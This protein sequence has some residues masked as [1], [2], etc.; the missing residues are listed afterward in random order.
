MM[1]DVLTREEIEELTGCKQSYR[2]VEWLKENKFVFMR[3]I[4][5][6]ARVDRAHYEQRVGCYG[7]WPHLAGTGRRVL[8]QLPEPDSLK[9]SRELLW[10]AHQDGP[11]PVE[12]RLPLVLTPEE[13]VELTGYKK[14]ADQILWLKANKFTF[15]LGRASTPRVDR[16][17]YL[18]RMGGKP[19]PAS[20]DEPNWAALA[21]TAKKK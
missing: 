7:P 9:A 10:K 16:T 1:V 12:V 19:R 17:H 3:R 14:I 8:R 13:L 2:Q 15:L 11:E 4:D 18:I 6:S 21:P 20:H 5:G